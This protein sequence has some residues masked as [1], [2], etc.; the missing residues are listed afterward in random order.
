M[1]PESRKKI[2]YNP[3]SLILFCD[4]I[5]PEMTLL[6]KSTHFPPSFC[7]VSIYSGSRVT[8]DILIDCFDALDRHWLE[9]FPL[10]F[11]MTQLI[12]DSSGFNPFMECAAINCETCWNHSKCI[13]EIAK[14]AFHHFCSRKI[15][16]RGDNWNKWPI[17][18]SVSQ[19]LNENTTFLRRYSFSSRE[20]QSITR[21]AHRNGSDRSESF[22]HRQTFRSDSPHRFTFS[23]PTTDDDQFRWMKIYIYTRKSLIMEKYYLRNYC[24][25]TRRLLL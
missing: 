12:T 14:S 2:T 22:S 19:Q 24:F 18:A 21:H 1:E 17:D 9:S 6:I 8:R 23:S 15:P 10:F 11:S 20:S 25:D 16:S 5:L 3:R 4:L 13:R 7:F